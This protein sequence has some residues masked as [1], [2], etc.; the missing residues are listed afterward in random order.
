[1]TRAREQ[2]ICCEDTPYDHC[3]SR[4]VR[5]AFLCGFDPTSQQNFEH[6]RQWIIDRLALLAEVFCVDICAYAIMSNH[7][8]L[9][10]YIDKERVDSLTNL[11][12]IERWR[13]IYTGPEVIQ[14]FI[15]GKEMSP[16]LNTLVMDTVEKWRGRLE[17]ISW[18][19]RCLN[20]HLARKANVED[21]CKGRFWEGRFKSQALLDEQALLTCMTYV[22]LN[23]IRANMA[24]TPEKSEFTSIKQRIEDN[25]KASQQDK[26]AAKTSAIKLRVFVEKGHLMANRIPYNYEEYLTLVD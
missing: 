21:N 8:H 25:N 6:R 18:F 5:K 13:K 12:V 4:V 7:Y 14:R 17:D 9:V 10:L 23:P 24:R 2:Q 20:E 11:E 26:K 1:M 15:D 3:I 22:E 16:E 19:M